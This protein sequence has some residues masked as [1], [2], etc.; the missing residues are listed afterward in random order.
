MKE[1]KPSGHSVGYILK[2]TMVRGLGW[3]VRGGRRNFSSFGEAL[4]TVRETCLWRLPVSFGEPVQG[5]W[6]G[7][8]RPCDQNGK[9]NLETFY[10]SRLQLPIHI[11]INRVITMAHMLFTLLPKT[12]STHTSVII[13]DII[14]SSHWRSAKISHQI[15]Q[16]II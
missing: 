16:K 10:F 4:T 6:K 12:A 14:G 15:Y 1:W 13:L 3:G 11:A 9:V 7:F 5:K 2:V 8:S